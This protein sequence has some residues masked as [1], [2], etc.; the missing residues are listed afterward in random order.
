[1]D[2]K[3]ADHEPQHS[4]PSRI[5]TLIFALLLLALFAF[6]VFDGYRVHASEIVQ[7]QP[8][9]DRQTFMVGQ[10]GTGTGATVLAG[11]STGG[12]FGSAHTGPNAIAY[13]AGIVILSAADW[14]MVHKKG[15]VNM[16][17]RGGNGGYQLG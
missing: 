7:A 6:L 1:M 2:K 8:S 4:G 17:R 9:I 12:A 10:G 5:Q 13:H 16:E 11:D 15:S 14:V 3:H